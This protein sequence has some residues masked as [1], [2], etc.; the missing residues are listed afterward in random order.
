MMAEGKVVPVEHV[1]P[2]NED[3]TPTI[4]ATSSLAARFEH[5]QHS[6]T[7]WEAIKENKLPLAWCIYCF[8]LCVTFGFD[9]LAG[10]VVVSI[11]EFRKDYGTAFGDDYVV[12]AN[13]QLGFQGATL[14]GI[15]FGG[16]LSGLAINKF[17]RQVVIL[18]AYIIL[19]GGVFGQVFSRNLAEFFVG[20]IFTGIVKYPLSSSKSLA[21][22]CSLSVPLQRPRHPMPPKWLPSPSAAPSPRV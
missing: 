3:A 22:D 20:K 11:A 14:F 2:G 15:I 5:R 9:G 7:R 8:F 4:V 12:D 21:N 18:G 6:L 13:W 16:W 10:G 1:E 17:G 19:V